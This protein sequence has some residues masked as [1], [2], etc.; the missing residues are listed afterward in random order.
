MK[1]AKIMKKD[2]IKGVAAGCVLTLA[3]GSA[4]AFAE[5]VWEELPVVYNNIKLVIN[6]KEVTPK[7]VNGNVV[8][9][10][11]AEGTT[12]LPVR[13]VAN[14]LGESVDWDQ[15]T[16]TVYIG[17]K[18]MN[19]LVDMSTIDAFEG[20]SFVTNKDAAFD[21]R[22][23]SVTP[24]NCLYVNNNGSLFILDEK[25]T[26]LEGLFAVPDKCSKSDEIGIQFINKDTGK[27][28]EQYSN[29][30]GE[31][32]V[33]VNVN[34]IGVDKL[35]IKAGRLDSDG[36]IYTYNSSYYGY[37]YNAYLTPINVR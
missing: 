30:K 23:E 17:E 9:P 18:L 36:S 4:V 37:F 8:E 6:G 33:D 35:I 10:F 2:F 25:Y 22:Q 21:L 15:E 1:G 16:S 19:N 13:A 32:A 31:K 20:N 12:Y 3:I 5:P 11:I 34:L 29:K 7:D 26:K 27:V 28:I 24:D 14:A